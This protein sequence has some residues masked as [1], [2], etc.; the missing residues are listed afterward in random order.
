MNILTLKFTIMKTK[1]DVLEMLQNYGLK[2]VVFNSIQEGTWV[3]RAEMVP[4]PTQNIDTRTEIQYKLERTAVWYKNWLTVYTEIPQDCLSQFR[5]IVDN[6]C[7]DEKINFIPFWVCAREDLSAK[8]ILVR[9][10]FGRPA[11]KRILN[12][13]CWLM[14]LKFGIFCQNVSNNEFIIDYDA[15]VDT[16][17]VQK[18]WEQEEKKR[19]YARICSKLSRKF[20]IPYGN[21]IALGT[22]E[23]LLKKYKRSMRRAAGLIAAQEESEKT[24]LYFQIFRGNKETKE[25]AIKS[26]GIEIGEADI[27]KIDFFELED[28]FQ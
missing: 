2:A 17:E 22:D 26:L 23:A 13:I 27:M 15:P 8:Q 24:L 19:Q 4:S 16:A 10:R 25:K 6:V 5:H 3:F 1:E 21:V 9:A 7:D 11:K 20:E 14:Q 12:K 28:A 18:L